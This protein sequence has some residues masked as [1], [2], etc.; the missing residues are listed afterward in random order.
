MPKAKTAVTFAPTWHEIVEAHRNTI[1]PPKSREWAEGLTDLTTEEKQRLVVAVLGDRACHVTNLKFLRDALLVKNANGFSLRSSFPKLADSVD[2]MLREKG[3]EPEVLQPKPDGYQSGLI[4]AT[5]AI[6]YVDAGFL[7][8]NYVAP[9]TD[10][11]KS[12]LIPSGLPFADESIQQLWLSLGYHWQATGEGKERSI[13]FSRPAN[14]LVESIVSHANAKGI[15]LPKPSTF[16]LLDD[17]HF[18]L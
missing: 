10:V 18:H 3:I 6:S 12:A 4:D 14:L 9:A 15:K 17:L 7:P 1:G 11:I 5:K 8:F 2:E 16:G 13:V